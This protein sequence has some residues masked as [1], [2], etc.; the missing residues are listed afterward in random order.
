MIN[1]ICSEFIKLKKSFIIPVVLLGAIVVPAIYFLSDLDMDYDTLSKSISAMSTLANIHIF[2]MQVLNNIIFS[3]IG[4]YVFSREYINKTANVWYSYPASRVKIFIGKVM[5]IFI[6]IVAIY[7]I[8]FFASLIT[9]GSSFGLQEV[10]NIFAIEFKTCL[11]SALL[12]ILI[13]PVPILI[14]IISKNIM[15][16]VI[17]G[18]VVSIISIPL[19]VGGTWM[20]LAPFMIPI[21]PFYYFFTGDPIDY[22]AVCLS[23]GITFI[24]TITGI[25]IYLKKCDIN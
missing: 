17:Y 19:H 21:V 1:I 11:I 7:F 5:V 3:L 18:V 8:N 4:G 13:M 16:P 24:V 23:G 22:I 15:F 6:L 10:K 25:I 14:G 20:Q 9:I 2:Q 12:Q